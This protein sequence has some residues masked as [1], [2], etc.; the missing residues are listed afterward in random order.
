[1]S[2]PG[3]PPRR[4]DRDRILAAVWSEGEDDLKF[5]YPSK[6]DGHWLYG[7]F[8]HA[9]WP[10][11]TDQNRSFLQELEERGYDVKT[12]RFSVERKPER[13]E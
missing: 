11:G 7:W 3:R 13:S 10:G 5:Y 4:K 9:R 6:P 12:L 1:M 8:S 2:G